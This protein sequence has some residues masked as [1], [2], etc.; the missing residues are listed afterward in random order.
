MAGPHVLALPHPAPRQTW[1]VLQRD[2]VLTA[3]ELTG[4][5]RLVS[6]GEGSAETG[7]TCPQTAVG[8]MGSS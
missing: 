8:R 1:S 7:L 2:L 3:A 4:S 6:D 5:A